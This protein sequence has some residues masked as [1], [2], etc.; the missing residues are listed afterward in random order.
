MAEHVESRRARSRPWFVLVGIV[1]AAMI[2]FGIWTVW[3]R[4]APPN[5]STASPLSNQQRNDLEELKNL[6]VGLLE[7]GQ[8]A[9]ADE[10]FTKIVESFPEEVLGLRN[11]AICR[12]LG[13]ESGVISLE[14]AQKAVDQLLVK[15]EASVAAHLIASQVAKISRNTELAFT[16]LTRATDLAPGDAAVAYEVYQMARDSKDD[17]FRKEGR[18]AL[19]RAVTL[20]PTNLFLLTERL[21]SQAEAHDSE[22]VSTLQEARTLLQWLSDSIKMQNR[23]DVSKLLDSATEAAK[24]GKW[25]VAFRNVNALSNVVRPQPATQ[26]DRLRVQKHPLEYIVREFSSKLGTRTAEASTETPSPIA[27]AFHSSPI[28]IQS[29]TLKDV[30][31]LDVADVDLDG[32][33]DFVILHGDRLHVLTRTSEQANWEP[34]CEPVDSPSMIGLI[35]ADLDQDLVERQKPKDT[36]VQQN[37]SNPVCHEADV[38]V[39]VFGPSGVTIFRNDRDPASNKRRL[40][41]VPQSDRFRELRDV[42]AVATTDLDHD[43]DL[44]L[45]ISTRSGISLWSNRGDM[46]FLD[47]SQNSQ[48]PPGDLSAITLL[49]VDWDRD[50]D[51]DVLCG[52]ESQSSGYLENTGHGRFRWHPFLDEIG[53]A[54]AP[55]SL[56][57]FA[58]D[59]QMSWDLLVG[60]R[61]VCSVIRSTVSA[62]GVPKFGARTTIADFSVNGLLKWDYDND[63]FVDLTT[64]SDDGVRLFRGE[65]ELRFRDVSLLLPELARIGVIRCCK[66]DDLDLDG[67]LDLIIASADSTILLTN[68]GGNQNHWLNIS[69]RA[70]Q[71]KGGQISASGRVNHYGIGSLIELR[72]GMNYQAQIADGSVTHFG[73]GQRSAD[74]VRVLWTNGVPGNI[75]H[76]R[77]E[78]QICEKQTLKGSCPYVY[79][80]NGS[81]FEFWTDLLWNAPLGLQF[82]EGVYASPRA[83]EYL[84][85]SGEK[86]REKEGFYHL[87][88]TEELWEAAYFDQIKLIAVDHPAD[89]EVYSNEKVGP[90]DIAAF[91]IHTVRHPITPVAAR[92]QRNRDV[93]E[94]VR[95]TDGRFLKAFDHKLRQG[96][97]EEHYLELDLGVLKDPKTITLF[98]TGWIYPTDTSINVS[99][100]QSEQLKGPRPPSIWVPDAEGAW[101]EVVPF[102]GFPGGKTKTIAI[103]LSQVFPNG[104]YRLR[105]VTTAELYWDSAFF[106]VD[107]TTESCEVIPLPLKSAELHYRGFSQRVPNL[108]NG[109]E[110]LDYNHVEAEPIWPPMDGRFTRYG[111]VTELLND[112]DD[113]QVILGSGDEISLKFI[114]PKQPLRAGWK[115]DF[116]MYNV[117]W[118]KDADLNSVYGQTVEPLP[119][120]SMSGYPYRS[121]EAYPETPLHE[122]YLKRY[123]TRRQSVRRFWKF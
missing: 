9:E 47:I 14:D 69:L 17:T 36:S 103:D 96:L 82:A 59:P 38:D 25:P 20:L 108:E 116:L 68:E 8:F 81:A 16:E 93:L 41:I 92:D 43:G 7:N 33:K 95:Q 11:L 78:Q 118:D 114:A 98:L 6:A 70:E 89:I 28:T 27:V 4:P 50:L 26:S 30:V 106:T 122:A 73:L 45:V 39:V 100:G 111:D 12:L 102:M 15:D 52:S 101:R 115:R 44:D 53:S 37:P 113:C 18:S 24:D 85:I 79:T 55:R 31:A 42:L 110:L 5:Q 105:I 22:I 35:T 23:V 75:I 40:E 67:D 109:P 107:E 84:K 64:W 112:E 34:L 66:A 121:D 71:E 123:Q 80:W 83:S 48:L 60:G 49:P 86:L 94:L 1:A 74:I 120:G 10:K 61:Q 91:K 88:V 99:L 119:F 56:A 58:S 76:P 21:L 63:G 97:A 90:A 13:Q 77:S 29:T 65:P 62:S 46:S 117:G 32:R 3:N 72:S 104:D 54:I 87:Q 2:C 57:L 19:E 51:F